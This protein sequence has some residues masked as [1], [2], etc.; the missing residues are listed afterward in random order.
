MAVLLTPF[1]LQ[2]SDAN[3][4][5]YAGGKIFTY[6]A[7]TNTPLAT[8]TDFTESVQA[9]NPIVLDS[10]GRCTIWI[11]G[12]Y[13]FV[14]EDALGNIIDTQDNVT[15]FS[16]PAAS[17]S[18]FFQSFSGNGS[19]LTFALS[20]ALGTDEN[21]VLVYVDGGAG[22]GYEI[23][24]PNAFTL[25]AGVSPTITFASAPASG[26]NNVYVFA[27]LLLIGSAQAS[28]T[29]AATSATN[30]AASAVLASQWATQTTGIVAATDYSAKAWAIG[31]TNLSDGAAKNWAQ[32]TGADV[33][34]AATHSRSAKSWAQENLAGATYGGSA[35]DWAQSASLPDGT[36][37]SAKSY[38]SD[39]GT[40]A[41]TSASAA[42]AASTSASAASTSETNAAASA[43][44]ASTSASGAATSATNAASSATTATTQAGNAATSATAAANS[45]T[46]ASGSATTATTQATNASTSATNAAASASAAASS[47]TAASSSQTAAASS[48]TAAAASAASVN[49]AILAVANQWAFATSTTMAD[50]GTGNIRLNNATIA[51]ASQLAIS[52]LSN[53]AGNPNLD[54]FIATWANSTHSPRGFIRI[55]KD[56]THFAIFGV[57]GA[58]TDNTTWLQIPVSYIAGA[59]TFSAADATFIGFVASG[60][61]GSG[62][63]TVTAVSVA[64]ANGFSGS[65]S[66]GATP[67]LTI[68]AS[69]KSAGDN[70]NTNVASTAY[71]DRAAT[72]AALAANAGNSA[73]VA[74]TVNIAGTYVSV[75]SGVGDTYTFTATGVSTVDGVVLTTGMNFFAKDLTGGPNVGAYNGLYRVTLA[76]SLGVSTILTRQTDYDQ[77]SDINN[78]GPI[79]VIQGTVNAGV[80]YILT[81]KVT[82]VGT[83]ALT[84]TLFTPAY[85]KILQN[86]GALGTPSSGT[87]T[88]CT[89]AT[90]SALDNSTNIASTAYVD[91]ATS[92]ISQNSKSAAYT[93]ILTDAGK[94]IYHPSADTTAR[95]WTIDS[96]ANV[97]YAIGVAITFVNDVSAGAITIAITSDTLV[98]AGTGTTGSR[99]LAAGG[100][101]TAL[102][103][104]TTR[105][106]ISGTGL[107]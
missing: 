47:A 99:T 5:P 92:I 25:V 80:S 90:K 9:T 57:N 17:S 52:A 77:S 44:A 70:S 79:A 100:T 106:M 6:A 50:P 93:T 30:A 27:P 15:A 85:S 37:K 72:N 75:G 68:S 49:S 13:K 101:A 86:G 65:S 102:K 107:T 63:G 87:L 20:S 26:T 29:A 94:H 41:A 76:G 62:S 16:V 33:T 21:A 3:G 39:S 14:L 4:V 84:Y 105:W 22:K 67:A 69:T 32:Q 61:D 31:G 55:E 95:I 53:D 97:A 83:D 59:G 28:A 74:T 82:N 104:G 42:S 2:F 24:N 58:L 12:S 91:A 8:F 81:T 35:K 1:I 89:T 11:N 40:S 88:N 98:L 56:A 46:S 34:G 73:D 78:T 51:S 96:N 45:A 54:T 71:A 43:S 66:G 103:I 48:A 38:A 19:T 60:N 64:T 7:G 18:S 10:A 23:Q 36:N